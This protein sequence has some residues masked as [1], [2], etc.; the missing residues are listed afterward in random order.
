MTLAL[1]ITGT[2]IVL[3]IGFGGL[4]AIASFGSGVGKLVRH[5]KV[6]ETL[7]RVGV[8]AARIPVLGALEILGALGLVVGIW[9]PVI[10]ILASLGLML[11]F[12]GAIFAHL[13][14]KDPMKE[15]APAIGLFVIA[16][17][18]TELETAR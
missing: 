11:Y 9:V 16:L 6:V 10:G 18:T 8:P 17:I 13:R 14:I 3:L 4:L 12:L 2:A 15:T 5:E 1:V 7:T